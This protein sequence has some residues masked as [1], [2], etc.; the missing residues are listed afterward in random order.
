MSESKQPEILEI[1]STL[2]AEYSR[3]NATM[4]D[5]WRD[6]QIRAKKEDI[7]GWELSQYRELLQLRHD[8][9]EHMLSVIDYNMKEMF[10]M[11]A[12]RPTQRGDAEP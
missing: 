10:K 4:M 5:I 3:L 6:I 12:D 7:V 8:K 11:L 1:L 2:R 9:I